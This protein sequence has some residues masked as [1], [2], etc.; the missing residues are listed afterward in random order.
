[1]HIECQVFSFLFTVIHTNDCS[2][3][4]LCHPLAAV[5][6]QACMLVSNSWCVLCNHISVSITTIVTNHHLHNCSTGQFLVVV[7]WNRSFVSCRFKIFASKYNWVTILTFLGHVTILVT[8]PLDSPYP[9]SYPSSIVNKPLSPALFE[10]LGPKDNW[11]T[12]LT[13]QGHVTSSVTWL[14]D[15]PYPI[16]YPSSIVTKPLY[17][18]LFEILGPKIIGSRLWPF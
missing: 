3:L 13:F 18:A 2:Q 8:W 7:H 16:S 9:I 6:V 10:I 12:I 4:R 15:S 14:L 1:M 11:V 17:T 5:T